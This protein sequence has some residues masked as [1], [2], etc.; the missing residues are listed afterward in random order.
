ME[1]SNAGLSVPLKRDFTIGGKTYVI[2]KMHVGKYAELLGTME[3]LP[4]KLAEMFPD[5]NW[6]DIRENLNEMDIESALKHLPKLMQFAAVEVTNIISK[7]TGIPVEV[8]LGSDDTPEDEI[9]GLDEYIELIYTVMSVN[10][11]SVVAD[12]LKKLTALRG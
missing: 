10:K 3:S 1:N 8:L 7:A 9:F 12:A 6:D 2:K 4:A 5:K 11:F